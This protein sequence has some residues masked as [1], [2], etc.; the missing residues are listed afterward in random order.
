MNF[1]DYQRAAA[2][3]SDPLRS[4]DVSILYAY[5]GLCGEWSEWLYDSTDD[6]A[7]DITW[8]IAELA[9]LWVVD[10]TPAQ[11]DGPFSSECASVLILRLGEPCK[12][13]AC[14]GMSCVQFSDEVR[15]VLCELLGRLGEHHDLATV[16][17][18]NIAKLRA[19]Y[20]DGFEEGGGIRDEDRQW[21][22]PDIDARETFEKWPH[23]C[24]SVV[25]G[26]PDTYPNQRD[27]DRC[28]HLNAEH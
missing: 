1:I 20:P 7:G 13:V 17:E 5:A 3:T 18:K 4:F 16:Y 15:E 12:K 25:V 21:F 24:W 22:R 9:R 27:C 11:G 10:V 23:A 14:H 26:D 19:R 2:R 28:G 8:H 6:E